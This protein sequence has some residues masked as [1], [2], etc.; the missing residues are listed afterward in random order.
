MTVETSQINDVLMYNIYQRWSLE[1]PLSAA[2]YMKSLI[3]FR[4]RVLSLT[5]IFEPLMNIAKF[6]HLHTDKH[7][8]FIQS[9]KDYVL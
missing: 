4:R 7:T 5:G 3:C 9:Q 8:Q 6:R 2:S 1:P